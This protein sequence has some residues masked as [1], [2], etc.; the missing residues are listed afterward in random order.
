MEATAA[1]HGLAFYLA[2]AELVASTSQQSSAVARVEQTVPRTFTGGT[3]AAWNTL[4]VVNNTA[5]SEGLLLF[6]DTER[7]EDRQLRELQS[8]KG[9]GDG[10]DGESAAA[11]N[12]VALREAHN[13]LLVAGSIGSSL[14]PTLHSDGSVLLEVPEGGSLRFSGNGHIDFAVLGK[15]RGRDRFDGTRVPPGVRHVL[16]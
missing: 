13:F 8:F 7:T 6:A 9:L 5:V 3:P 4:C 11:P 10:W 12:A 16:S 14:E 15:G 2:N 1:A